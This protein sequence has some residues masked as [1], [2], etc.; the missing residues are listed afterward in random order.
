MNTLNHRWLHYQYQFHSDQ[1]DR[2]YVSSRDL[3]QVVSLKASF[4]YTRPMHMMMMKLTTA[5]DREEMAWAW[6][7]MKLW[8]SYTEPITNFVAVLW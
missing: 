7:G 2:R 8:V 6:N 4:S 5:P 3:P 1:A